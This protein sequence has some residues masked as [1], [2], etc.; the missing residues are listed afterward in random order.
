MKKRLFI[1][2]IPVAILLAGPWVIPAM[3]QWSAI[4]SRLVEI[5][6]KNGQARHSH[7]LWCIKVSERIEGTVFSKVLGGETVDVADITIRNPK[8]EIHS[9][10]ILSSPRRVGG[11]GGT[12]FGGRI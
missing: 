2:I 6:I 1:A 8:S 12:G 11:F 3:T 10:I 9:R 5:N 7:R 4:N